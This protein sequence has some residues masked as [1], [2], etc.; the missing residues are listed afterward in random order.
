M[1]YTKISRKLETLRNEYVESYSDLVEFYG[2]KSE[3]DDFINQELSTCL[4][5][6]RHGLTVSEYDD[7]YAFFIEGMTI[8]QLEDYRVASEAHDSALAV[9]HDIIKSFRSGLIPED[10]ADDA[11]RREFIDWEVRYY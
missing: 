1:N 5:L 6:N 11:I 7:L 9:C 10:V 3:A 2:S 4:Y 8:K